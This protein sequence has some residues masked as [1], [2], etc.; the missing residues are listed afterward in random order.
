MKKFKLRNHTELK[1]GPNNKRKSSEG[2]RISLRE[3]IPFGHVCAWVANY[4]TCLSQYLIILDRIKRLIK[5]NGTVHTFYYLKAVLQ[6]VT[7]FIASSDYFEIKI[8]FDGKARV[9]TDRIGLPTIIPLTQR[10][11]IASWK[12]SL[13][14]LQS[15]TPKRRQIIGF[16]TLLSVY[17]LLKNK[18]KVDLST[19]TDEFT[20]IIETLN[21]MILKRSI[22]DLDI[23]LKRISP[24]TFID[25]EASG[26]NEDRSIWGAVSDCFAFIE[27]PISLWNLISCLLKTRSYLII[28]CFFICMIGSLPLYIYEISLARLKRH[29]ILGRLSVIHKVAGKARV[30]GITNYWIQIAFKPLHNAIFD[31]LKNIPQDGTFAQSKPLLDLSKRCGP[32][33]NKFYCF[34]LSAA[35]DR[36]PLMIQKDI[37]SLIG[38][39][40][41]KEWYSLMRIPFYYEK[42]RITYAVGQPMGALSSWASLALTHH[43]LIRS[44]ALNCDISKFEDYCILGDDVVIADDKVA[45]EYQKIMKLLGVS[46]NLSKSIISGSVIE[47]AK[48]LIIAPSSG[49]GYNIEISPIGPGLIL[50]AIRSKVL[51]NL[52]LE[53]IVS[54]GIFTYSFILNMKSI[55]PKC[56][57]RSITSFYWDHDF[58][59]SEFR[60]EVCWTTSEKPYK[61]MSLVVETIK[62][63]YSFYSQVLDDDLSLIKGRELTSMI[64]IIARKHNIRYLVNDLIKLC[65]KTVMIDRRDLVK[66]LRSI[67]LLGC[68]IEVISADA[69]Q[70][71]YNMFL[72]YIKISWILRLFGK[73]K[74]FNLPL[75][76][77]YYVSCNIIKLYISPFN[78]AIYVKL[79]GILKNYLLIL[80]KEIILVDIWNAHALSYQMFKPR[81][82]INSI[83]TLYCLNRLKSNDISPNKDVRDVVKINR[84]FVNIFKKYIDE[85]L[86]ISYAYSG[87]NISK[88]NDKFQRRFPRL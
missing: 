69:V 16:L 72:E 18:V 49:S 45:E 71:K 26:P 70:V 31:I 38:I 44:A 46:I 74:F 4:D 81:R 78:P 21:S 25:S 64:N 73:D 3:L 15:D 14:T 83:L 9:K 66:D 68:G 32:K 52:F 58:K 56:I 33:K 51:T 37:L 6:Q 47:F 76:H 67:L 80:R 17:R 57:R 86:M 35:T 60:Y 12:S 23:H 22:S 40:F 42:E 43:V 62:D 7:Q 48:K 20:G 36:L 87:Y 29:F 54:R 41:S 79:F 53:E 34:D 8:P 85:G 88:I 55:L 28:T 13:W 5:Y 10:K 75:K 63:L 19:V 50:Q 24:S 11:I 77:K 65:K 39:T 59:R 30:I 61:A 27:E 84:D 2:T 1:K 82:A